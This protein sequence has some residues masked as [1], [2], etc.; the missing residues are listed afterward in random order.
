MAT[1]P[2]PKVFTNISSDALNAIR[3][4]ASQNYRNYVPVCTNNA[5]SIKAVGAVIMD[6]PD[7]RNEFLHTLINRIA[8]VIVTSKLYSNPW[9]MFKRGILD[10]GE[11]IENVFIELTKVYEFNPVDAESTVFKREIPDVRTAFH[12]MNYQKF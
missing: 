4:Q 11:T 9:S 10:F 8:L 2:S 6:S 7:L 12:V 1:T 3:N 5:D